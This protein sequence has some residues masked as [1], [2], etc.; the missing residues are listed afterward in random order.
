[1][2][3][4]TLITLQHVREALALP[5]FDAPAAW[6]RMTLEPNIRRTTPPPGEAVR[7]AGVLVLLYPAQGALTLLLIRRTPDPGVHSGQ[8]GF[9]G[10]AQEAED[11]DCTATALREACEEVGVCGPVAVLGHLTPLYIPPSR[12]LVTP[13]VGAVPARPAFRPNAQEVAALLELPL[14]ELLDDRRKRAE[15]W[16]LGGAVFRVPFYDVG[17][18]AVWGATALMLSELEA[19]L[20]AV[21]ARAP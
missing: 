15:D 17:G 4:P 19:R 20:R 7:Q 1:M 13:T 14:P 3:Y 6:R 10:G 18:H 2:T 5:D 16:E 12:Y 9:P 21:L 11:A 8:V